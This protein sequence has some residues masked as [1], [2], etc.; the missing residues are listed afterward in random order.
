MQGLQITI[1]WDFV[2][3]PLSAKVKSYPKLLNREDYPGPSVVSTIFQPILESVATRYWL[4]LSPERTPMLLAVDIL[5]QDFNLVWQDFTVPLHG[6]YFDPFEEE[7]PLPL[8]GNPA[9]FRPG[10]IS[11]WSELLSSEGVHLL[12][13]LAE[14]DASALAVAKR[15]IEA[16]AD[17]FQSGAGVKDYVQSVRES[18]DIVLFA[19]G[20][21]WELFSCH[22]ELLTRLE[23]Y[24][25]NMPRIRCEPLDLSASWALTSK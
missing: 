21:Q 15:I 3:A 19:P 24:L 5:F 4:G 16:A 10:V 1:E 11:G 12:G 25:Q 17:F 9:L 13:F 22:T 14:N 8:P 18:V 7:G 2:P 20:G 6:R 23:E